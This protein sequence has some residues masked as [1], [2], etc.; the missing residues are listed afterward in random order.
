MCR[1]ARADV[2]E[3]Y[4]RAQADELRRIVMALVPDTPVVPP[5]EGPDRWRH[6][7]KGVRNREKD[8]GV[9]SCHARDLGD[10][11]SIVIYVLE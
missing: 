10:Y 4:L 2:F 5:V 8:P 11:G 1:V 6:V 3:S 9:W 7:A